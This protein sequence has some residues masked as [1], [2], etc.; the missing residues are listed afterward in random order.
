MH[1]PF[2]QAEFLDVFGAYNAALWPAAAVL[3]LLTCGGLVWLMTGRANSRYLAGLL[4]LHWIWAGAVY[5][6]GYFATIN[7]AARLFGVLFLLEG[8]LIVWFGVVRGRWTF[9]W[10]PR[11]GLRGAA[12]AFFL[13]YALAYPLLALATGLQWPRAPSFGV[14]C[15]TTILTVGLVLSAGPR[16]LRGLTLIPLV[17]CVVGGSAA[18]LFGMLPD[19]ALILAGI[20]LLL[21]LV[22]PRQVLAPR[23]L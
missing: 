6:L 7:P 12:A 5:H 9:A 3:W 4:T 22:V 1:L 23:A 10:A 18:V 15:P 19:I 16:T 2:T 17:W 13:L 11:A 8:C 21:E 14:P 20:A